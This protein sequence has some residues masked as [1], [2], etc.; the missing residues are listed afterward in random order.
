[1]RSLPEAILLDLDDT[2]LDDSGRVAECW[3][4]ACSE[5]VSR[6]GEIDSATLQAAITEYADSWWSSPE[7][8]A[9]GRVGLRAAT[10]EVVEGA[11][12]RLGLD[13]AKEAVALAKRYRDLREERAELFDGAIG[14]LE[15]LTRH[16]VRLGMMT[17]GGAEAQRAKIERFGLA[18]YFD[19]VVIEGEFGVGKPDRRV[20][21][22]LL[23]A[24]LA[25]PKKTWAVGDNL[26]FDVLAPMELG[27]FGV[28][29]DR[30]DRGTGGQGQP[31]RVINAGPTPRVHLVIDCAMSAG[32]GELLRHAAAM[33]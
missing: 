10:E 17:N 1:M 32:L 11:F 23:S 12:Q 6:L 29:I 20:F 19:H 4:K 2:I 13:A 25:D 30:D 16:G 9:R 21:D 18:R 5:M 24:L 3:A 14:V 26:K 31:H 33:V 28:W 27:I 15:T 22:S 7:R 8:N